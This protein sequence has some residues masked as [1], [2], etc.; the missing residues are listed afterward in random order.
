MNYEPD[1]SDMQFERIS[2]NM[3]STKKHH[4]KSKNPVPRK[5]MSIVEKELKLEYQKYINAI[6][7]KKVCKKKT[8]RQFVDEKIGKKHKRKSKRTKVVNNPSVFSIEDASI[9]FESNEDV[10][11]EKS[12]PV[13]SNEEVS[14][15]NSAPVKSNEE[16]NPM[17][18]P[19]ES[20]TSLTSPT[21][22]VQ[23]EVKDE[24]P[25]GILETITS[26]LSPSE[27]PKEPEQKNMGGRRKK[28]R[29]SCRK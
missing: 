6:N 21:K 8:F 7:R 12:V 1:Y 18:T 19:S 23:E 16:M 4:K 11:I 15:E 5:T 3:K 29:S 2:K 25:K 28:S 26:A 9:P 22:S 24:K 17:D 13:E 27:K 14:V 10:S 20:S